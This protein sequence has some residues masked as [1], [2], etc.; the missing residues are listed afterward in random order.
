M[1]YVLQWKGLYP[2][3]VMWY[4]E[5]LEQARIQLNKYGPGHVLVQILEGR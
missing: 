3:T 5:N 4:G 1:Y 2:I